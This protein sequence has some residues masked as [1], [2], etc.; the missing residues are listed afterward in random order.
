VPV[1]RVAAIQMASA[2]GDVDR[3]R[4]RADALLARAAG[5]DLALLPELALNGYVLG[6][7]L[8]THAEPIG[9]PLT[10]WLC[11]RARMHRVHLGT[12]L[13]EAAGDHFH[14]SFVLATPAGDIAGVV[15]K[16]RPAW[17]EARWYRG[18]SGPHVIGTALGRIGVGI[19][20]EN[21]LAGPLRALAT[22][23]VDL[24]LQPT[25][26]AT[27]PATWPIGPRGAATFDAMLERLAA[28]HARALGAPV[29]MAN[30]CGEHAVAGLATRFPGLSSIVDGGGEFRA[31]LGG[32]EGV[33]VAAMTLGGT[34]EQATGTGR[35]YWAA[36]MPWYAP[37][38]PATQHLCAVGYRLDRER[39]RAA[40]AASVT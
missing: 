6:R 5:S 18:R 2:P 29:I 40:R 17:L 9:G 24:V 26:A 11:D 13:I 30:M 35:G 20:Y 33:I 39:R 12:T 1:R 32:E 34:R 19:C 8:W 38:W 25:A 15:R 23:A 3:N 21:Y 14:N 36:P 37:V 27:P 7:D 28:E 16:A 31:R 22:A 10:R 4:D